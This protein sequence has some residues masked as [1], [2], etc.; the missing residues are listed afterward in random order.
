MNLAYKYRMYPNK[1]QKILLAKTFGCVRFLWNKKVEFWRDK[2]PIKTSTELRNEYDFLQEVS[3][4]ALQQKERDFREYAKQIFSKSRKTRIGDP[5]FKSRK[6]RQSYRLPNQ[7][8]KVIG[9]KIQLEKIGLIRIVADREYEGKLISVTVSKDKCGDYYASV[10]VETATRPKPKT[11][12][13]VGIDVG[14]KGLITTSDGLQINHFPDN[15]RKIKHIQRHL[16]RKVNG[17]RRHNELKLRLNKLYR[18]EQRKREWILHNISKFLVDNY[19]VIVT[20]DLNVSG[21]MKNHKLAGAIG[22]ASWSKLFRQIEYKTILYGREHAQV[23]RFYPSSKM[24][25]ACGQIKENLA[26]KD[27]IYK[28]DCGHVE[29]RDKNAAKNIKAGGAP[30]AIQSVMGSQAYSGSPRQAFPVELMNFL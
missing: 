15:Q 22:R 3:A 5:S 13:S 6:S 2:E 17:S 29:D 21:M 27:R 23:D 8:F 24:C 10:L 7:K 16:S 14:L 19:D 25:S 1:S 26:L 18:Q 11:G 4:G 20:E 30:S 28:C 9:N 12:N